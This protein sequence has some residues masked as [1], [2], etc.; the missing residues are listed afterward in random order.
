VSFTITFD[1]RPVECEEGWTIGAALTAAGVRSWRVTRRE[2]RPRGLFCG[3]GICFDCLVTV[4]GTPSLRA[5]LQP[6]RP[7]DAVS[8]QTGSGRDELT[9]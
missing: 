3:I 8:I 1:G 4:N 7:G 9:R 2:E 6:A 5:C